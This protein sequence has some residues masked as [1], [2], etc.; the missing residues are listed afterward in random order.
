MAAL[1]P[2]VHVSVQLWRPA[3][4]PICNQ[5]VRALVVSPELGN[6]KPLLRTLEALQV[7]IIVCTTRVQTNSRYETGRHCFLR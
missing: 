6:R 3:P 4:N 1:A 5:Y 2:S 7:D